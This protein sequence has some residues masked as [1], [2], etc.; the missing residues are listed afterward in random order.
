MFSKAYASVQCRQLLSFFSAPSVVLDSNHFQP[1]L[2]SAEIK[3][4]IL[5]L[6]S[7]AQTSIDLEFRSLIDT[8]TVEEIV[9]SLERGVKVRILMTSNQEQ[10]K[11]PN[12]RRISQENLDRLKQAGALLYEFPTQ[13]INWNTSYLK[14]EHHRKLILSDRRRAYIGSANIRFDQSF[15]MGLSLEG[16][17]VESL[18]FDFESLLHRFHLS[19]H[20]AKGLPPQSNPSSKLLSLGTRYNRSSIGREVNSMIQS[21]QDSITIATTNLND[22]DFIRHLSQAKRK[23]PHLDI[24]ILISSHPKNF[25]VGKQ[26]ISLPPLLLPALKLKKEGV[27]VF[28]VSRPQVSHAKAVIVDERYSLIGSFDLSSRSLYGNLEN[29]VKADNPEIA[30]AY[31]K[32][33]LRKI[34]DSSQAL[35]ALSLQDIL[36]NQIYS[37]ILRS[38]Q[39]GKRLHNY[40]KRR[41]KNYGSSTY[42]RIISRKYIG[43]FYNLLGLQNFKTRAQDLD[44]DSS[45]ERFKSSLEK[46]RPERNVHISSKESQPCSSCIYLYGGYHSTLAEQIFNNVP[47][48]SNGGFY[49]EGAYLTSSP[50]VAIDYSLTR[51]RK[52]DP[53]KI[54]VVLFEVPKE[55]IFDMSE[56]PSLKEAFK[57]S[58][59]KY[60]HNFLFANGYTV[61]LFRNSEGP[62]KDYYLVKDS[63]LIR[64]LVL[65]QSN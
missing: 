52:D 65:F 37:Q 21:A 62:G 57:K 15:E 1:L 13:R 56:A 60:F 9:R 39:K 50:E 24:Q 43:L 63:S 4:Q 44:F 10:L 30:Q 45:L 58:N 47:Y 2:S 11:S 14:V 8:D 26:K 49:G 16:P 29:A 7:S 12:S 59:F 34:K 48:I 61:L 31:K 36:F 33:I 64:P 55:H 38:L 25:T 40:V 17:F 32:K 54:N 41:A 3:D 53:K 46:V 5:Q 35:D 20:P 19:P 28:F 22:P 6:I 23:K 42:A 51:S 18:V 27:D